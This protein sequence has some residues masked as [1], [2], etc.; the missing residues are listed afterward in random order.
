[1]TEESVSHNSECGMPS[2]NRHLCYIVAQGFHVTEP[3][4]YQKLVSEPEFKCETCG[5]VAKSDENLC[6]PVRL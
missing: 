1:M 6:N 2:H 4:D 5:R 3:E